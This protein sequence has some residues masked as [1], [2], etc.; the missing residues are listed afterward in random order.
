VPP[1]GQPVNTTHPDYVIGDG[2]PA[3][4]T[5][6]AVVEAVAAGG[7]ITFSRTGA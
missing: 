7:V 4:C 5:S 2:T 1:A 6:Q 3:S